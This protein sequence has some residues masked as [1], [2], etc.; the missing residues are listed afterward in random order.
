[1]TDN[2]TTSSRKLDHVRIVLDEDVAAKGVY[3]G[4]AA[5]RLPHEALPELDLAEI[6]TATT[7]LSR[8][9]RAPLLISSMTGGAPDVARINLAL[10]EAAQALGLAMGVGSQRSAIR[11]ARLAYTYQVRHVAPT[12]PLLLFCGA[13]GKS[14]QLLNVLYPDGAPRKEVVNRDDA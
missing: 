13:V 10:A 3:T 6:D 4:F 12:I 1:M 2:D 14:A 5:Y 11:D 9:L 8:R 7:F